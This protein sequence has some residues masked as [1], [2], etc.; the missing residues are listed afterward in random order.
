MS[1]Y[2]LASCSTPG[3]AAATLR[4]EKNDTTVT[5]P[6][7]PVLDEILRAGPCGG[8]TFICGERRKPLK[9]ESFGNM[10]RDACNAAGVL[11][12]SA[13]GCARLAQTPIRW[14]RPDRSVAGL[15]LR[16]QVSQDFRDRWGAGCPPSIPA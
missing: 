7:L 6:I 11:G 12:K 16:I 13:H 4:T 5:I 3:F 8:L 9:K 10:F 1:G 15:F 14:Y 2:S